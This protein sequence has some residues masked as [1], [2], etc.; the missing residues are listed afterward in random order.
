MSQ[1]L[2]SILEQIRL[3]SP[4]ELEQLRQSL[5]LEHL[6]FFDTEPVTKDSPYSFK[7]V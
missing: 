2:Q 1:T 4:D 6:H 5:G 7:L 3:L